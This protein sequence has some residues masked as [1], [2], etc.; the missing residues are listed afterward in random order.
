MCDCDGSQDWEVKA[1]TII[2]AASVVIAISAVVVT[3]DANRQTRTHNRLSVRPLVSAAKLGNEHG[4]GIV[5]TNRGTGPAVIKT[6]RYWSDGREL[7][8]A[9]VLKAAGL[10]GIPFTFGLSSENPNGARLSA[11]EESR[12]FWYAEPVT[13]DPATGMQKSRSAVFHGIQAGFSEISW[14][15][16]YCSIYDDCWHETAGRNA[17]Q[18]S[19]CSRYRPAASLLPPES[20]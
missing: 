7:S 5:L 13:L 16:C 9:G 12:L 6:F 4:V 17:E 19:D 1:D 11:G 8:G 18:V 15:Y 2:A 20:N 3:V 10:G 14:D